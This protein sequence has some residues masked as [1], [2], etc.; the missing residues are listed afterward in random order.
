MRKIPD[1]RLPVKQN[2]FTW[3][4]LMVLARIDLM[5][6]SWVDLM[7]LTRVLLVILTTVHESQSCW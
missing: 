6:L 2:I 3:I 7:I 5:I 4:N 1:L